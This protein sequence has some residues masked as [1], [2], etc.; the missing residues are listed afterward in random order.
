MPV[1][2]KNPLKNWRLYAL[3]LLLVISFYT[4]WNFIFWIGFVILNLSNFA[5]PAYRAE[6]NKP[7]GPLIKPLLI[8]FGLILGVP[9]IFYLTPVFY[10]VS[11]NSMIPEILVAIAFFVSIVIG[12]LVQMR[13]AKRQE[14]LKDL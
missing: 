5:D 6:L 13:I 12:Y 2:Q 1:V 9:I 3:L 4:G 10:N 7:A 14:I 11:F 8:G